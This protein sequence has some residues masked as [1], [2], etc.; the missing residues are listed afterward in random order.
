MGDLCGACE[1][2]FRP[3]ILRYELGCIR[4]N[5]S[6]SV[7]GWIKCVAAGIFPPTMLFFLVIIL[8]F[9]TNSPGFISFAHL[10]AS[11][12]VIYFGKIQTTINNLLKPLMDIVWAFY[13][14]FSLDFSTQFYL[15]SA[16]QEYMILLAS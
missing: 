6:D 4:C 7:T 13:G 8:R 12:P 11:A 16:F 3:P 10:V 5:S 14:R 2:G 15:S 1:P 9:N